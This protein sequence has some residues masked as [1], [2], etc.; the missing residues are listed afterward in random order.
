MTERPG[1][2]D[3]YL[4]EHLRE[5]LARDPR[6]SG[7]GVGVAITAEAVV[8]TGALASPQQQQAAVAVV[9]ELFPRYA[10]RDETTLADLPEPTDAEPVA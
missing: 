6:V 7:L 10:V 8:L 4:A 9:R 5:A 2:P 3:P 1:D